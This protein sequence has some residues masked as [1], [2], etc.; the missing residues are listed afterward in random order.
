MVAFLLSYFLAIVVDS[1]VA[2]KEGSALLPT[3]IFDPRYFQ[4]TVVQELGILRMMPLQAD[5]TYTFLK[6]SR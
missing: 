1:F 3:Y 6:E 4:H 5:R 2:V